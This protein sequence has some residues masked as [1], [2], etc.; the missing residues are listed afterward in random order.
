MINKISGRIITHEKDFL[1]TVEWDSKTGLILGIR[2]YTEAK[3]F[4][5]TRPKE[6]EIRFDP[7]ETVIFPG[8]GDIHIH[9]REDESGK[10]IYKED[11][12]SA[13]AAA[14]NGGVIHVA[15]MPNNPI[16][17]VDEPTY[18]KKRKLAD[19]SNIHITLYAGIGPNTKPL[20]Q[21]VPYKVFMGPSIGEL[22][23]HDNQT[24]EDTI[25]AYAG[26]NVSF[27]CEDPEILEKYQN[28]KFHEDRRPPEAETTATDF[29]L[30][31]IEKYD[32]RGKL[33]H[34]S[35]GKGL[36]KIKLAKQKDS[37]LPVK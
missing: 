3:T 10:H 34:Y 22:F 21:S 6:D 28:E 23:F 27:H 5:N 25:R 30:Y 18:S 4:W 2:E 37:K 33:C 35:T 29:A 36:S 9:A 8:F 12:I 17:P 32:L 11:F 26:E 24:L 1:G 14:V 7:S 31:L 13:S 19:R 15:D 20:K 16:P